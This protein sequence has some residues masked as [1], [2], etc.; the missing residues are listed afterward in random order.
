MKKVDS[1]NRRD[2]IEKLFV[3]IA[4]STLLA[5]SYA[6]AG[7]NS[8][9]SSSQL[10]TMQKDELFYMYQEE[11]VARDVYVAFGKLYP[12]EMTFANIQV[13]EQ[14]HMDAVEMLCNRYGINTSGVNEGAYGTFVLPALQEL[15]NYCVNR[16]SKSLLEA[17]KVGEL[18]EITDIN[19]LSKAISD[20]SKY[21]DI[22]NVLSNL[23]D[24]SNNHLDAFRRRI[25]AVS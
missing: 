19:D 3:M 6:F 22:V 16:G 9:S 25:D 2:F 13:S 17:L 7:K 15:Y 23:R 11:K 10:T 4:G 20:M 12:N 14:R 5:N 1:Q 18:I 21:T 24:G 8:N